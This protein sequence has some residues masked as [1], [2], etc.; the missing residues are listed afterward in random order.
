MEQWR[1]ATLEGNQAYESCDFPGALA[2]Y[3]RAL[4]L[5]DR[6]WGRPYDPGAAVAALVVSHHNLAQLHERLQQSEAAA[7][8]ICAAHETLHRKAL[9]PD[10]AEAWRE[11]AWQHSRVTYAEL[12]AFLRRHPAHPRAAAAAALQWWPGGAARPN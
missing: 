8:H 2:Q 6:L 12:L 11:A 7:S 10:V 1:R 3:R 4:Q 9:D 5:A